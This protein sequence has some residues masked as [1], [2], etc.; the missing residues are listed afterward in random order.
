MGMIIKEEE[1]V[2]KISLCPNNIRNQLI[3]IA[4]FFAYNYM[5]F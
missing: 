2:S 5:I 1:V 4:I 3:I